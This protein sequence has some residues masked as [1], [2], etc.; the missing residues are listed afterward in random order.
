MATIVLKG[1]HTVT[2]KGR[3]YHYAWRGGPRVRGEPGT[4]EFVASYNEAVL[5]RLRPDTGKFRS[6]IV[7]YKASDD[8]TGLAESTKRNWHRWLDRIE[9]YFGDLNVKQ[10]DRPDRIRPV[11]RRWRAL[12][13][14][15]PRTADYGMQVL[16][17]I[18]AYAVDPLSTIAANPCEGMKR[19]YSSSRAEIIWTDE[20]IA[21][22][23]AGRKSSP[24][25]MYAVDLA[26]HTGL[27]P[28]DL[29]RLSWSHVGKEA[30]VITTNKSRNRKKDAVVPLYD[31]L[32]AL[33]DSI[34]KR[35]PVILTN[36]RGQPWKPD[37]LNSSF[38]AARAAA[39]MAD[40]DLNFYDLRGT[41]ATK[42]YT[43]GLPM[44]VIAEIMGWQEDYVEKIIRRYVSRDAAIRATID[45]INRARK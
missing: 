34:P 1:L 45:T 22:L 30:A 28:G 19:L 32:R 3:E 12:Y 10:F 43:A 20:D 13:A 18:L 40:R 7:A 9:A 26:A 5:E 21:Q 4:A 44:R 37:G 16:S 8:F 27:R 24:E 25:V 11:I 17:R 15:T 29:V 14:A 35:S 41:A 2:A 36:T 42:F 38:T 6:V 39:G 31:D 33:L 23:R